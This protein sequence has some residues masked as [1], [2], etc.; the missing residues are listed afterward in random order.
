MKA[1]KYSI[2]ELFVN[3]YVD[4]IV[5]PEIQRDYVWKKEQVT[6][7]FYSIHSDFLK[8]QDCKENVPKI[9]TTDEDLKRA[10]EEFFLKRHFSSNIGFI[11]AY[12]DDQSAGKY[13]LIDGQQR[14]TTIF[15]LLLAL[16]SD[17][18]D[19]K[20]DFKSTY[21]KDNILKVDYKV[22]EAAHQ[23]LLAFV[24]SKLMGTTD[25]K[26]ASWYFKNQYDSDTTI[27]S[28]L[29]N[30]RTLKNL[31]STQENLNKKSLY[32]YLENYVSFWYFDTNVSEQGEELYIYMNA[33]G[34][35]IQGNENI[36][37]DL[38]G[39]LNS[40]GNQEDLKKD[41][42]ARW[43]EWQDFFW[44]NKGENENADPGF[45]EF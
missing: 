27:Q 38:L 36:K 13:F 10:F 24:E 1:G 43:E 7:L 20:K 28:I 8:F 19:L 45:N 40:Q 41:Y 37:A 4:Q 30:F 15:L 21:F 18:E 35:Q 22:R 17:E 5:I 12:N 16:T 26:D 33:R 14:I 44:Q 34:E 25:I 6:G 31:I 2:K 9:E 42:G 23:F 29:K 3:R 11:Y 39:R 32:S